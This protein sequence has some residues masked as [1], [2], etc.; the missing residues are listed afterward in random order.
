MLHPQRHTM[1]VYKQPSMGSRYLFFIFF[2]FVKH[3]RPRQLY[4]K[5]DVVLARSN[6]KLELLCQVESPSKHHAQCASLCSSFTACT[7]NEC[8]DEIRILLSNLISGISY[9]H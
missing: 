5:V 4:L 6:F 7:Y 1:Y 3:N 9:M 8:I 2:F